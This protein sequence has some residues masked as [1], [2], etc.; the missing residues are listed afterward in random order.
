MS[1]WKHDPVVDR[2]R[3]RIRLTVAMALLALMAG[4]CFADVDYALLRP[5]LAALGAIAQQH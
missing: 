1:N 5:L 3:A 2:A 4:A